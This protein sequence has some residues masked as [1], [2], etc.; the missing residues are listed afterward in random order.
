MRHLCHAEI[1]DIRIIGRKYGVH[2]LSL[3]I[4]IYCTYCVGLCSEYVQQ[5]YIEVNKLINKLIN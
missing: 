5:L 2:C 3:M 1:S 4:V